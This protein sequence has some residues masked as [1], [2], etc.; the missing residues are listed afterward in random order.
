MRNRALVTIFGAT[1]CLSIVSCSSYA[2]ALHEEPTGKSVVYE[3][4]VERAQRIVNTVMASHF[5]GRE[6]IPLPQPAI[7]Y[8]TYTRMALDT[9]STTVTLTPVV[10]K[11]RKRTFEAIKIETKGAGSSFLTGR[12]TYENFKD[13]LRS[14]LDNTATMRVV[15]SYAIQ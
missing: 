11:D 14:E 6:V 10:A 8:T 13:R 4:P 2:P 3:I 15:D 1:A 12:I 5:S 7:G 9:W